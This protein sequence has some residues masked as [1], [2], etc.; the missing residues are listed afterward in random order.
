MSC[1]I[2]ESVTANRNVPRVEGALLAV[3][4]L[5]Q[6]EDKRT[7]HPLPSPLLAFAFFWGS[8]AILNLSL[9]LDGFTLRLPRKMPMMHRRHLQLL[10]RRFGSFGSAGGSRRRSVFSRTAF[11]KPGSQ[12]VDKTWLHA[13]RI[14]LLYRV[15]RTTMEDPER[16]RERE[17]AEILRGTA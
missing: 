17:N 1:F 7:T 11:K 6:R 4:W 9:L 16:E 8:T 14:W 3:G 10:A 2:T 12:G 13:Y 5:V 15:Q